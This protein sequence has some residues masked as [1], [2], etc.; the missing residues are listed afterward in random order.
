MILSSLLVIVYLRLYTAA[1]GADL[2]GFSPKMAS[3]HSLSTDTSRSG[4]VVTTTLTSEQRPTVHTKQEILGMYHIYT[5]RIDTQ[6]DERV[7]KRSTVDSDLWESL[8]SDRCD[9]SSG[10]FL[11]SFQIPNSRLV[12]YPVPM[13]RWLS[14]VAL[15]SSPILPLY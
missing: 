7:P 4:R 8:I 5:N 12:F 13:R 1:N 15:T 3:L 9:K 11:L 6:V 14:Q 2:R 10:S